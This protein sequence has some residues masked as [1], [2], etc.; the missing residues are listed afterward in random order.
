MREKVE[1]ILNKVRPYIK[2][3]NGDVDL[4]S[5]EDGVVTLKISGACANCKMADLTYNNLVTGLIKDE[6]PDIKEVVLIK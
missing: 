4:L 2:M 3:H 6:V 5:V 1:K